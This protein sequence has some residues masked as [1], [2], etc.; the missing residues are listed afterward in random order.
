M[1]LRM[2]WRNLWRHKRRTLLTALAMAV[3]ITMTTSMSALT[4]GIIQMWKE[5][6][7]DRQ[8]GHIQIHHPDYPDSFSPYD[9]VPS[10]EALVETLRAFPHVA[11]ATARVRSFGLFANDAGEGASGSLIGVDFQA[12]AALTRLDERITAGVWLPGEGQGTVLAGHDL[13]QTLGLSVGSE[14]LVVTQ[15][16]NGSMGNGLF[17]VRGIYQSGN[18][19]SD[20][21]A[22]FSIGDA[23]YLMA[24]D[25]G[26]HEVVVVTDDHDGIG[27][28]QAAIEA[29]VP[30]L[31]VRAWW[32]VMPEM[33]EMM[34]LNDNIMGFFMF[35][36][37]MVAAFGVINTLFMS[38]YE[39]TRELG[40]AKALGMRPRQIVGLVLAESL[41]LALVSGAI[42]IVAAG[43]ITWPLATRGLNLGMSEDQGFAVGGITLDP[44]VYGTFE[45]EGLIIPLLTLLV[46]AILGG[47]WPALRAARFDPIRAMRQE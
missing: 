38:V 14:L 34:Q 9:S 35:L 7:I 12:E 4:N 42:G 18:V 16:L 13:A 41:L 10:G 30:N 11:Q 19:I 46:V 37:L 5:A 29:E 27:A 45:P 15:D 22:M 25:T 1:I 32:Q 23:Q 33:A 39:R 24:M 21:G 2:A 40:V 28:V 20:K 8:T 6:A 26:V 47:L 36:I 3:V 43:L 31:S 44:R 17:T